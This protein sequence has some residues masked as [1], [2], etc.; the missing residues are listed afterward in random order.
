MDNKR[1]K[2]D[3]LDMSNFLTN[4]EYIFFTNPQGEFKNLSESTIQKNLQRFLKGK[5][6][7]GY[8]MWL[9]SNKIWNWQNVAITTKF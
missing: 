5:E 3:L 1:N 2:V 8:L 9:Q 4:G 6:C 7:T